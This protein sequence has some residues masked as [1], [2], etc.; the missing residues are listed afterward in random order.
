MSPTDL[1]PTRA[2]EGAA[3]KTDATTAHITAQSLLIPTIKAW[4]FFLADQGNSIH[5]VK[6]FAADLGLLASFI[7]TER[8]VGEITLTD[9]NNFLDWLQK[10]R[11]VPCSPKSLSRRITSIKAFFRWLHQYGV[12]PSDPA[13]KVL[14]KSVISPLPEVLTSAEV[15]AVLQAAEKHRSADKPDARMAAL[16]IFLLHTGIKKGECLGISLNHIDLEAPT[17]PLLFVRYASPQNRYKERKI[18]LPEEWIPVF[19]EYQVQYELKDRLFPWS[20]RR[21]EY[22]LE[23]LSREAGI[24]KHLSFD[25]CR[26]TCALTDWQNKVDPQL[27]RQKLGISKIQWR[28]VSMKLERIASEMAE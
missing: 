17:G 4:R 20:Q 18:L 7:P 19:K 8:G 13:E 27:I 6:A 16:V 3:P 10:G 25:M 22:L 5:T 11:G 23:D 26:W 28:E 9:L 15:D 24:G 21:L 14:Q 12:I 1:E 2:A